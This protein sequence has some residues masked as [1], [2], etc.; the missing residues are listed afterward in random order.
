MAAIDSVT[1][2]ITVANVIENLRDRIILGEYPDGV[3]LT[4]LALAG[5]YGTSRALRSSLSTI[6]TR[7][8]RC[9][10]ARQSVQFFK[11]TM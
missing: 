9:W 11:R 8:G 4:E 5:E 10:N 6:C 7:H 1:R 2:T 3:M